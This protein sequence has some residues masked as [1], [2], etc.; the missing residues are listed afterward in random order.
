MTG[1][2]T[3]TDHFQIKGRGWVA[4]GT[5]EGG[6]VAPGSL[7]QSPSG[8][9]LFVYAVERTVGSPHVGLIIRGFV[10]A[11]LPIGSVVPL[12]ISL[13]QRIAAIERDLRIL[14]SKEQ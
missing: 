8:K 5:E 2:I 14:M 4:C 3:I 12:P 9:S 10:P 6:C 11:D 1:T 7:L 13:E